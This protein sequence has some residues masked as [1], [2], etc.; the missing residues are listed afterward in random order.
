[1]A[2]LMCPGVKYVQMQSCFLMMCDN[3][4]LF[5]KGKGF[6]EQNVVFLNDLKSFTEENSMLVCNAN[7]DYSEFECVLVES[8]QE[9]FGE[10]DE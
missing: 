10:D 4:C 2:K 9:L 3:K 8:F 6:I 1:M 7:L 5:C